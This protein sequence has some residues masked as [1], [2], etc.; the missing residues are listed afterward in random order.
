MIFNQL[1]IE[2]YFSLIKNIY[3]KIPTTK[4]ILNNENQKEKQ[5]K[6]KKDKVT[7]GN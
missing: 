2:N 4:I 7:E 5:L 3:K 1:E 6:R